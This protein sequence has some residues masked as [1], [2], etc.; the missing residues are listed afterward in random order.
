MHKGLCTRK[1]DIKL[2]IE[3]HKAVVVMSEASEPNTTLDVTL[4]EPVWS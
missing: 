1:H 2:Q 3:L 4:M